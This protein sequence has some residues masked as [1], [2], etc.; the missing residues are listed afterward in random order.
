MSYIENWLS[1]LVSPSH[2]VKCTCTA[3]S[4]NVC[5]FEQHFC[6]ADQTAKINLSK[7]NRKH[8]HGSGR[9]AA[10]FKKNGDDGGDNDISYAL[11]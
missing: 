2:I 4:I 9:G 8:V 7:S 11:S 6:I 10:A 3:V 1:F 5:S